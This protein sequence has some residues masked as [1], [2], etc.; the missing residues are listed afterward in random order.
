MVLI[1]CF[2]LLICCWWLGEMEFRTKLI[3]TLVYG[4]TWALAA[5][6]PG[7]LL[8]AQALLAIILGVWTFGPQFGGR[9]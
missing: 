1:L 6:S 4:G 8:A 9:R 2:V 3:L 5:L 7:Y